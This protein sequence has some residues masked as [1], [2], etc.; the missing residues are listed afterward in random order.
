MAQSHIEREIKFD[1]EAN[2]IVPDVASLLP[3]DGRIETATQRLRSD[4][5]DTDDLALLRA[6]VTLRRRSG[7][8]DV[9]WQLKVPA[10]EFREEIQVAAE[11]G[12]DS[13]PDELAQ[14]VIGVIHGRALRPSASMTTT[15]VITRLVSGEDQML[16][17]IADDTVRAAAGGEAATVTTWREVEVELGGGGLDLLSSMAKRLRRAGATTSTSASKLERAL[18]RVRP[19]VKS[20]RP[21]RAGAVVGQY[22]A[23]QHHQMLLGDI[24]LRRGDESVVHKTRVATRRLRST[25]RVFD[26]LFD[27]DRSATLD[28]E[29]RWYAGVLGA[30]RDHQVLQARLRGM[31]SEV[32]PT[33]LLGPVR[34]RVN[35]ELRREWL[36]G[37]KALQSALTS[38]RYLA[39]LAEIDDWVASPP[40]TAAADRGVTS[41][42]APVRQAQ[43]KVIK[44]LRMARTSGDMSQLHSARKAAKRARYATEATASVLGAKLAR[45]QIKHYKDL[46]DVLGEHQDSLVS[47]ALLRRIGAKAGAAAGENGFAYGLLYERE[48]RNAHRA[49]VRARRAAAAARASR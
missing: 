32:D 39:L 24:A 20:R 13:V 42:K 11:P 49:E 41:L 22:V 34:T 9:G 17:E 3:P 28:E 29:L 46:Q 21:P 26:R 30:V 27:E 12:S 8:A 33:L 40:L 6:G 2:F 18:G 43:R 25:L 23:A 10:D 31:I 48:Q 36:R 38:E 47:A 35:R 7:D 14:L 44:R 5:F 16:A 19:A 45:I 1:V 37:W 4:Y 15:R